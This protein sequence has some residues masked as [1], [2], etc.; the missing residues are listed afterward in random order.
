[1]ICLTLIRPLLHKLTD[2]F[3]IG[4]LIGIGGVALVAPPFISQQVEYRLFQQQ[5]HPQCQ[6]TDKYNT[7]VALRGKNYRCFAM[8]KQYPFRITSWYLP[9]NDSSN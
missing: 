1:M 9:D 7:W 2:G 8:K 3:V 6:S 4:I 5:L